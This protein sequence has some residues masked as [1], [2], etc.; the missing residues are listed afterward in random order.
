MT[1]TICAILLDRQRLLRVADW[2]AFGVAV[3]L[4]WSTSA[5]GVLIALWLAAVLPT[6]AVRL[7][8]R[9]V[10]SPA[11][12][13]PVLLWLVAA[14]GMLWADVSWAD[15]FGGLGGYNRLLT[16]PLL[17]AQF[18]RSDNGAWVLYGYLGSAMCLVLA[19]WAFGLIPAFFSYGNFYGVPVKDYILQTDEFL[20]CGFAL[21]GI[22]G[23]IGAR[24][25]WR[26]TSLFIGMGVL[27]LA[28][29]AFVFTSRTGLL[30]APFLVAAL[31]WRLSGAKGLVIAGLVAVVLGPML[32]FSSPHLRDFA[33]QSVADLHGYFT[34][35]A[36][37]SSGLHIEFLRKSI[38]I[39]KDA[40]VIGHG[41]GTIAEQF[42]RVAAEK[43]GAEGA[44]SINPHNQVFAVAIQLGS[45]G[46]IVLGAMWVAHLMLFCGGGAAAWIGMVVVIEN[47]VSSAVNSHL[48]D[49]TQGWLYVFGV[50]VAGGMV[51]KQG[52]AAAPA[53]RD[54][55]S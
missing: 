37:S 49:F 38:E 32:W 2:L 47:V 29:L 45:V 46:A 17:L 31:G 1:A 42:R 23:R 13:L 24:Q 48:F 21:L 3:S 19:S 52:A 27:F 10:A 54:A 12:G 25:P 35:N 34:T 5:T 4:P 22:S 50:G 16:V 53:S 14:L 6:L 9:E 26:T 51:L 43:S 44:V 11:G 7:V 33:L 8:W 41:T 28:N 40:P 55:A 36:I 30:V 20:I 18:R 15:R 39:I